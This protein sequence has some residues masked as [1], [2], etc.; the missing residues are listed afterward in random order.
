MPMEKRRNFSRV[1]GEGVDP[2]APIRGEDESHHEEQRRELGIPEE[3]KGKPVLFLSS[4]RDVFRAQ[5]ESHVAEFQRVL[6]G[7]ILQDPEKESAFINLSTS[8]PAQVIELLRS[9]VV[10]KDSSTDGNTLPPQ[11][12]ENAPSPRFLVNIIF[13]PALDTKGHATEPSQT[14]VIDPFNFRQLLPQ[15]KE[16]LEQKGILIQSRSMIGDERNGE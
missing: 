8:N 16:F 11:G 15:L 7:G 3:L 1:A 6:Q 5:Y 12:R 9:V 14:F 4:H 13:L 2:L 10:R